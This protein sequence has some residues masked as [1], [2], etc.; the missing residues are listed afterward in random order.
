M[1]RALRLAT[2]SLGRTWP[3]PGVAC[4]LVKNGVLIGQ[5][6][7]ERC[8]Q[9]HAEINALSDCRGR[10]NDP[11]HA[12]AYVTL[13][14]CTR[15][16]RTPPC[17]LA[18]IQAG[19]TRIVAAIADPVQDDP[20]PAFL[21]E[22]IDYSVG[23]CADLALYL[24]GGFLQ[25]VTTGRP[26]LTG[27]WAMTLDGFLAKSAADSMPLSISCPVARH[28]TRRRRRA[29][30]GIVIGVGTL[31]AD[32]PRL[33]CPIAHRS[34]ARIVIGRDASWAK[35]CARLHL[36]GPGGQQYLVHDDHTSSQDMEI[37][38]QNGWKTLWVG[39][40]HD[41]L[42][43]AE[44]LG[45]VGFNDLLVEG[46]AK[47]H[48]AWLPLYDQLET[49]LGPLSISTGLPVADGKDHLL[50]WKPAGPPRLLGHSVV[51]RHVRQ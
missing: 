47:I 2:L 15:V 20:R 48:G 1:H 50:R 35:D 26:R 46:G 42:L 32:N 19:I 23:V 11:K 6:R 27:K 39:N 29:Y 41:P 18:L 13:A 22:G 34:P 28:A 8:G 24:H 3:N 31:L 7:H 38:R 4:V 10:G 9:A 16:G 37:L 33:D 5:G 12:T 51:I 36:C 14:P 30:D 45:R 21:K 25:R 40:C 49:T 44:C 17:S 43:V